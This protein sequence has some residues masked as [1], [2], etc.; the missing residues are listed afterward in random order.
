MSTAGACSLLLTGG[1]ADP[2]SSVSA[3]SSAHK[4]LEA[5]QNPVNEGTAKAGKKAN[6]PVHEE[7][8]G[9]PSVIPCSNNPEA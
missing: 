2:C 3:G 8:G 9:Q 1:F 4:K 5:K 7:E 6:K